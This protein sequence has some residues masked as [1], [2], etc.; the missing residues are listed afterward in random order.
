MEL[1]ASGTLRACTILAGMS[2]GQ[3]LDSIELPAVMGAVATA[4]AAVDELLWNRALR[5]KG[6]QLASQV[7]LLNAQ[8]SAALDGADLPLSAW[9]AGSALDES[10]MGQIARG[11]WRLESELIGLEPAWAVAPGQALA[12][13][14]SLLGAGLVD[15]EQ[16]GRPRRSEDQAED[17]MHLGARP[18]ELVSPTGS[19]SDRLSPVAAMLVAVRAGMRPVTSV[20][21]TRGDSVPAIVRAG[22]VHAELVWLR[23][24]A[25]GNGPIARAAARLVL[26]SWGVDPNLL[27]AV[28]AALAAM[29]RPAYVRALR[30]YAQGDIDGGAEWMIHY[31]GA[32]ASGAAMSNE[33]LER[34]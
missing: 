2:V 21:G 33:L 31:S 16:L 4:R 12:R 1:T 9:R 8:A 7:R 29:G 23:P 28:D 5:T 10:P 19:T 13:M 30:A 6:S 3:G 27:S 20:A 11:V 32:I 15:H 17:P 22:V 26:A 34:L 18:P 25:F 14:H 24:F